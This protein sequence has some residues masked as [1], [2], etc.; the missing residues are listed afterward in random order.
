MLVAVEL[1]KVDRFEICFR[2]GANNSMIKVYGQER[3]MGT[4]DYCYLGLSNSGWMVIHLWSWG[5]KSSP[6]L[7]C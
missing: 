1:E 7:F 6:F 4:K 5:N 2:S 3:R